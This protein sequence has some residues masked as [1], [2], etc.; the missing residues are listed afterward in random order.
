ML[1]YVAAGK[2]NPNNDEAAGSSSGD[3][4]WVTLADVMQQQDDLEA[5]SDAVLGGSDDQNCTYS[6]VILT[7]WIVIFSEILH[8]FS[9]R[10]IS[11]GRHYTRA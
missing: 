6:Q 5:E 7:K 4:S 11:D 3:K 9:S 1:F 10:V 2:M 8:F